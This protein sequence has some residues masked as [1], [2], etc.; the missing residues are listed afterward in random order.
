MKSIASRILSLNEEEIKI[1]DRV[2][3]IKDYPWGGTGT[4]VGW[5]KDD[6]GTVLN[7]KEDN[8]TVVVD[9]GT[10]YPQEFNISLLRRI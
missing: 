5:K 9:M 7:I 10:E 3:L 6:Q 4:L 8:E 2:A 1:G